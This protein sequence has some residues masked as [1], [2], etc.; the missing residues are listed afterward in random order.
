MRIPLDYYRILGVPIQATEGQL[1]Q[2]YGDRCL[3]MPRREYSESA[4]AARKQLL[5]ESYK[6]LSDPEQRSA[7][8]AKFLEKTG[9]LESQP[10]GELPFAQAGENGEAEADRYTPWLEIHQEQLVG[11][12]LI[13]QEL[14]EYELVLK[15]GNPDLISRQGISGI[16]GSLENSQK[17]K[18]D[19][20]LTM[21]LAYLE[22]GREQWQQ[23]EY[24]NAAASGETGKGLLLQESLFSSVREEIQTDLYK[25]RPY[26]ILELLALSEDNLTERRKGLQLL[27]EMLQ[28][29][30]GIDGRKG[31]P[32][33]LSIDDFLRF[34]QQ[35]R[36]YLTAAEQQEL[37]EAEA[38][39]PSAV[40]TY[41]AVYAL[42]ARG[43]AEREPALIV[44]AKE[45]LIGLGKRQDVHL[46]QAVCAL[47]LG[48]TEEAS[49][50][51][52]SSQEAEPLAFIR[53]H[54][55]GSPDLLPGLCLYGERWLQTEVFSHFRNLSD[56]QISLKEYFADE[57]VQ[58]YLEQLSV[59][60]QLENQRSA[61]ESEQVRGVG[62]AKANSGSQNYFRERR[63]ER[64]EEPAAALGRRYERSRS[65]YATTQ[66]F[67]G[68]TAAG[69]AT[70]AVPAE[71]SFAS[72]V[73]AF[74]GFEGDLPEFSRQS[75]PRQR[76]REQVLTPSVP[77]RSSR[78]ARQ[79]LP[80]RV[81]RTRAIPRRSPKTKRLLVLGMAIVLGLGALG[82]LSKWL[83][84]TRSPASI[85]EGEQLLIQ[86]NQPP[87][88]LPPPDAQ[89][90][91]PRG[92]LTK[93]S[94]KLVIQTWL[95]R[96]SQAFGSN[97]Q[98]GKLNAILAQPLLSQWRDRAEVLKRSNAHWQYQHTIQVRSV[99]AS[100]QN[101]NQARVEAA[102]R[103][104]AKF[105]RSGRLN[106]ARSYDD[107]LLVRYDLVRQKNQWLIKNIRVLK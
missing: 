18:A 92:V 83:Q 79:N 30:G 72:S 32:S 100:E 28:E 57:Q 29:R 2:A 41:L 42:L 87:V 91:L 107:N 27:K 73:L 67:V 65:R 75:R 43:F 85:L 4:I 11:A 48:Q 66:G 71:P 86:L 78:E 10:E 93:E 64:I 17:G 68:A 53:E 76:S 70:M 106:Q 23:G 49:L 69:A 88:A 81:R 80:N 45:M 20:V 50:A 3:Q 5:D 104:T 33:G 95:E 62:A 39:R 51:L 59:E 31:D 19:I 58:A 13:L 84:K 102:V 25:L 96:K 36:L 16:Q 7:Y 22:L 82:L 14:G 97:H 44:R 77:S 1:S 56:Q 98:I 26:R 60:T 90:I 40:A 89:L 63:R 6:V 94:A 61:G 21:A 8:D 34:I 54:S 105:Y 74:T 37:F 101:P 52:E 9:E 103:E 46:E 24:E 99:S 55:Q 12:L 38:R 15:L 47:L 35:L